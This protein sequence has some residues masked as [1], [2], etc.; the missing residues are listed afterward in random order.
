MTMTQNRQILIVED[1]EDT[2]EV[3]STLL[4][5]TGYTTVTVDRGE[6]ALHEI[7]AMSPDLVL[8]DLGLPD[9]HGLEVLRRVRDRSFLPMIVISGLTQ[10]ND[11]VRA[12]EAGA[13]DFMAKPFSSEELVA[14]VA[15]LLRR[16]EWTPQA[17]TKLVVKELY[18]DIPHRQATIRGERLHLTPVEYGLLITL[19]RRAGQTVTHDELL[20]AVWGEQ[21]TGDYSVLRVNISR[22]RQKIERN[23][24][25]PGY[26]TT[27][28]GAGYRMPID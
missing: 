4:E 22:L 16:V 12:L 27:V 24:R 7:A 14:R 19:M 1:D 21:Y 9:M 25:R 2:A 18:L 5:D 6:E 10:D 13:D 15:A 8:L 11:K 23:P 26:I 17:E 3:V 20:R 28:A